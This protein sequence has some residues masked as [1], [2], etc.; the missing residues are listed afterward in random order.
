[1]LSWDL[2][3]SMK[4]SC[5]SA[6]L[7]NTYCSW[8][9]SASTTTCNFRWFSMLFFPVCL[10]QAGICSNSSP[11]LFQKLPILSSQGKNLCWRQRSEKECEKN[12]SYTWAKICTHLFQHASCLYFFLSFSFLCLWVSKSKK[13]PRMP[14]P[15]EDTVAVY[16]EKTT[17]TAVLPIYLQAENCTLSWTMHHITGLHKGHIAVTVG[18]ITRVPWFV[19]VHKN[20][21]YNIAVT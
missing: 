17:S 13:M 5:I 16:S 6:G 2:C 9:F 11:V 4:F 8:V 20:H 18:T 3:L 19:C 14:H 12:V 10:M 21:A 15:I 7:Q 1:M